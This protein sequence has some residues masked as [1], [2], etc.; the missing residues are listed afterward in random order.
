MRTALLIYNPAAGRRRAERRLSRLVE[1]LRGGGIAAEAVATR[2]RG[3]ATELARAAAAGR[4]PELVLAWGGDGTVRE[5]AAGLLGSERVLG[6]LPGGTVNVVAGALGLPRHDALA[7]ARRLGA[8]RPRPL[9][10]GSCAGH[11]F[12]MQATCGVESFVIAGL[13]PRLKGALGFAG[14]VLQAVPAL[15]SY[16]FP[17]L[18]LEADG[19]RLRATGVMVCNISEVLGRHRAIP[20]GRHDDGRLDLLLFRGRGPRATAGFVADLFFGRHADRGDVEIRPVEHVRIIGPP[21]VPVQIDG[22][23]LAEPHPIEVRLLPRPLLAL[24]E[25]LP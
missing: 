18:E 3:H 4:G 11:P 21:T 10:V 8:L 6:V 7:A 5:V 12:L 25:A 22:D 24:A 13:D 15:W 14:A 16:P 23:A 1:A 19:E 20:G 9:D 2:G 17:D